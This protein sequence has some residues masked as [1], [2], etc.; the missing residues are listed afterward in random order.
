LRNS[1]NRPAVIDAVLIFGY[2]LLGKEVRMLKILARR[3]ALQKKIEKIPL[4]RFNAGDLTLLIRLFGP[5]H[6]RNLQKED[7]ELLE[8]RVGELSR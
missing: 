8:G 1:L 7:L 5:N 4:G 2:Y 6:G 3:K